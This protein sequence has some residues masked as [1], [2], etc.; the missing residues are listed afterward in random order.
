M[1]SQSKIAQGT[2]AEFEG[3]LL[4]VATLSYSSLAELNIDLL[5]AIVVHSRWKWNIMKKCG[6][7]GPRND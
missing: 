6:Q 4:N 1:A 3:L 5:F 7:Q 2:G